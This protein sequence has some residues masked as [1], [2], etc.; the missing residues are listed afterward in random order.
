MLKFQVDDAAN[1]NM[2]CRVQMCPAVLRK[3]VKDLF[4]YR[5]TDDTSDLSVIT[6]ILKPNNKHLRRNKEL[7][8]EKLAQ[9][10]R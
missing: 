8:T 6:V 9:T 7:E 2:I 3:T 1:S 5:T 4:P 10:V